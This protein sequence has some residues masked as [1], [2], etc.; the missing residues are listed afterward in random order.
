[1][2]PAC[3]RLIWD[4]L[5]ANRHWGG[6]SAKSHLV[7][8]CYRPKC[9]LLQQVLWK[10]WHNFHNLEIVIIACIFYC[11]PC[12]RWWGTC[13]MMS[14]RK[15]QSSS[16]SARVIWSN[17]DH[18]WPAWQSEWDVLTSKLN[19]GG[20]CKTAHLV[21]F[22]ALL[23][24]LVYGNLDHFWLAEVGAAFTIKWGWGSILVLKVVYTLLLKQLGYRSSFERYIR[25]KKHLQKPAL[26]QRCISQ[27]NG[28]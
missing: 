7:Q 3:L 28:I 2:T 9:F 5:V 20:F 24:S 23:T 10:V 27:K 19:S 12:T 22:G 26:K 16:N 4:I 15:S 25:T 18:F 8:L 6:R 11:F 13:M 21:E 14:P 17:S 1:M